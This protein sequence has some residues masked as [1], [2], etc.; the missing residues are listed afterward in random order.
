MDLGLRFSRQARRSFHNKKKL[1]EMRTC[2]HS[3]RITRMMTLSWFWGRYWAFRTK[4]S[5]VVTLMGRI[6]PNQYLKFVCTHSNRSFCL[7]VLSNTYWIT[8]ELKSMYR[9]VST[10]LQCCSSSNEQKNSMDDWSCQWP[11]RWNGSRV[12][13]FVKE[14]ITDTTRVRSDEWNACPISWLNIGYNYQMLE[15]L[16]KSAIECKAERNFVCI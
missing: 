13:T 16:T 10:N 3:W 8:S 4:K 12:K 1:S 2:Y 6:T 11:T 14:M 7:P 9:Q 5:T 15:R